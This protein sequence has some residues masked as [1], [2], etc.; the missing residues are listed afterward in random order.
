MIDRPIYVLYLSGTHVTMNIHTQHNNK[1]MM[2]RQPTIK[3]KSPCPSMYLISLPLD[4]FILVQ[5]SHIGSG[6]NPE[7]KYWVSGSLT[8]ST[9][10][11][12][13]SKSVPLCRPPKPIL[14]ASTFL[15][16]PCFPQL[17]IIIS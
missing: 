15:P 4:L 5:S 13:L 3:F 8:Y 12:R 16:L 11:T 10:P 9:K 14:I 1:F 2:F 17:K 7:V 6:Y